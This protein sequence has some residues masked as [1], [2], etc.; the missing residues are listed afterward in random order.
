[1]T[2]CSTLRSPHGGEAGL[3]RKTDAAQPLVP[4]TAIQAAGAESTI[5]T[6]ALLRMLGVYEPVEDPVKM[7]AR[8]FVRGVRQAPFCQDAGG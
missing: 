3:S 7:V 8:V 5:I 6:G 2:V 1:M 4:V